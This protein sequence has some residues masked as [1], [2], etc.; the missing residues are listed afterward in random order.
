MGISKYNNDFKSD[1]IYYGTYDF[2]KSK[3]RDIYHNSEDTQ[4]LLFWMSYLR[5][6]NATDCALRLLESDY[7]KSKKIKDKIHEL[8]KS[9]HAI[10]LTLTFTDDVLLKTSRLT[11]RKYVAR[12]LKQQSDIY[13]ANIDFSP[14]KDREHYHAVV[15]SRCDLSAWSYGFAYAEQVRAHD[16]NSERVARYVAKL[17]NHALKV[18]QLNNRLIYSRNVL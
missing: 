13:V 14:E 18:K 4:N 9:G 3:K 12:Y 2:V 16:G 10:F 15:C 11:R 7:R 6:N 8:V 1:V 17:T 5:N